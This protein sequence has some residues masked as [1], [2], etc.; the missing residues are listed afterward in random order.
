MEQI[1]EIH[2]EEL[3]GADWSFKMARSRSAPQDPCDG[4]SEKQYLRTT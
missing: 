4:A 1:R 3:I 2:I